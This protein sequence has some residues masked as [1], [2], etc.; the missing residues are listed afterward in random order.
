VPHSLIVAVIAVAA[1]KTEVRKVGKRRKAGGGERRAVPEEREGKQ[2][3]ESNQAGHSG[4]GKGAIN[5][6]MGRFRF[7]A[8]Q[9]ISAL[10]ALPCFEKRDMM[11]EFE[12]AVSHILSTLKTP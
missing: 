2:S 3:F 12:A 7:S 6:Q 8:Q 1:Q 10:A 9:T 11:K 5:Q 4:V